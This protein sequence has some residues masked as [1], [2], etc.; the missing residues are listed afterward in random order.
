MRVQTILGLV[1][2]SLGAVACQRGSSKSAAL[3]DDLK[4]DL[5]AAGSD[6]GLQLA[7]SAKGYVPAQV[8]S[9]IEQTNLSAPSQQ[10]R[11]PKLT[12]HQ[13]T[14]EVPAEARRTTSEPQ[15]QQSETAPS[16]QPQAEQQAPAADEPR[17]PSVAPRP[18]PVPVE[19]GT[20]DVGRGRDGGGPPEIGDVIGVIFRGGGRGG[21]DDDHCVPRRRPGGIGRGFPFP[22]RAEQI[23]Q[24]VRIVAGSKR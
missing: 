3:P 14:G 5:Q 18:A 7:S 1:A 4:R 13:R 6:Q 8:V 9:D 23:P 15:P 19:V 12:P 2:V 20:A 10:V 11:K 21:V 22:L 17:V 16:P 24:I